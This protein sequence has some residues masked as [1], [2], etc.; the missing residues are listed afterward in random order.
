MQLPNTVETYIRV[1][2]HELNFRTKFYVN[3]ALKIKGLCCN[4]TCAAL[5]GIVG[6]MK[7]VFKIPKAHYASTT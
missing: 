5:K 3:A 1:K 7:V 2:V 6:W 4:V